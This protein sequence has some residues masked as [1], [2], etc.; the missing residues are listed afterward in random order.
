LDEIQRVR[1]RID[2]IDQEIILLLR[3]R[4]ENARHLGRI[5]QARSIESRDPKREKVILRNVRRASAKLGLDPRLTLPIFKEI[6]NFS[7]QAQR[8]ITHNHTT[9]IKRKK[10]LVVG[11]TSGM[12]RFIANFASLHE[13]TVKIVGRTMDRTRKI[14]RELEVEAGSTSDATASDIVVVAVPIESVVKVSTEIAPFMRNG[15]LLTDCL[16]YTSPSPRDL[17]TSRMPSSA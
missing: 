6:F 9:G 11:G 2:E 10:I 12:G 3:D 17:S 15:A 8:N 16:L 1:A 14:A 13:A 7:V 4:Y 5:K